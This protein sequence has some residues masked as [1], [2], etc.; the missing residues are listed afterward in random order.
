MKQTFTGACVA[1]ATTL[2]TEASSSALIVD[3]VGA[4]NITG[5]LNP[6]VVQS[7][8]PALDNVAAVDVRVFGFGSAGTEVTVGLYTDWDGTDVSGLLQEQT[9]SSVMS[10]I[11]Q[12]LWSPVPVTPEQTYYLRFDTSLGFI[13]ASTPGTNPYDRGEIL[14]GG[15]NI[16]NND[17]GFVTYA[18]PAL[19]GD[20]DLDGDVDAFDLGIW[21]TGFG[22]MS[23]ASVT[24]GDADA[25]GDV[26][27]FDLGIWQIHFG[28]GLSGA[29]VPEPTALAL[30]IGLG[31]LASSR[32]ARPTGCGVPARP[33]R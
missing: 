6:P 33:S 8:K 29:V 3:Q 27:A 7:F 16:S 15:G 23:G 14:A 22:I 13:G 4:E 19:P 12:V 20:F 2:L 32:P 24:D 31:L 10:Q 25:D 26:D 30:I 1:L 18:T 17:V 28:T 5:G 9:T 11:A 21:Q